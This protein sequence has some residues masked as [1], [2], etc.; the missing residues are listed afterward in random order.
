M[1]YET[2]SITFLLIFIRVI[3]L[4][5]FSVL[6]LQGNMGHHNLIKGG[7]IKAMIYCGILLASAFYLNQFKTQGQHQVIG[8]VDHPDY[9]L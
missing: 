7:A 6:I 3:Q 2:H 1:S 9:P 4:P 8:Q 5:V